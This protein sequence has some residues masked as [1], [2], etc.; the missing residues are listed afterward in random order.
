MV[1]TIVQQ[2][3]CADLF[4]SAYFLRFRVSFHLVKYTWSGQ[5]ICCCVI[6]TVHSAVNTLKKW[7]LNDALYYRLLPSLSGFHSQLLWGMSFLEKHWV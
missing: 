2:L 6:L 7:I 4:L 5:F 1:K 3:I